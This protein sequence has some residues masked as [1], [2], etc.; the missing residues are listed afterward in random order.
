M[1]R[2]LT[3]IDQLEV[4]Q[5]KEIHEKAN[6]Y[7]NNPKFNSKLKGKLLLN[8]F[9][10]NSTRTRLSFEIAAKR[11]GAEVVNIDVSL[12]SLKK[13]ETIEDMAKTISAMRPHF[14]TIRHESSGIVDLLAKHIDACVINAG[15]GTNEHPTQALLDSFVIWQKKGRI[16]GLKVAICGDVLHSRGARSNLKL[17]H[18]M[19]AKLSVVSPP[20]LVPKVYEEWLDEKFG[21]KFY[22][23]LED[24]IKNAD[25]VMML[26]IQQERMMGRSYISS[27][28]EYF[29]LYGL[30]HKR[31]QKAAKDA[32]IMHP[33]PINRGV[34]ISCEL[35]DD[36]KKSV[37]LQQVEAGVA[38][39]QA[40]LEIISFS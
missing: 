16:N 31:L 12:S 14:V 25:V 8:F 35:A 33:G 32:I 7:F 4:K 3:S 40:L 15:D 28:Q 29:K 19:G 5:I 24:G 13:G 6:K 39:R 38:V 23:N 27:P 10:E 18:K 34:E 11:M 1:N 37:I 20:T 22:T 26:R 2:N 9:F 30:T 36:E 17:L 21:A